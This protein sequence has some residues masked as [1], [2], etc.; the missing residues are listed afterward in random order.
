LTANLLI[1]YSFGEIR[2]D[3]GSNRQTNGVWLQTA[4]NRSAV[5]APSAPVGR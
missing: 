5:R 3:L 1:L 4:G 2:K